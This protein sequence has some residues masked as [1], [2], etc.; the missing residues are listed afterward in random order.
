MAAATEIMPGLWLGDINA[1][2][3]KKFHKDMNI[4]VVFNCTRT[5]PFLEIP[6]QKHYRIPIDDNLKA[7][8]MRILTRIAG[9]AILDLDKAYS[10]GKTILVHCHAGAQRSAAVVAMYLI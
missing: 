1:S 6:G 9:Q 7:K 4:S 5:I 8:E 3:D 10:R 2:Q